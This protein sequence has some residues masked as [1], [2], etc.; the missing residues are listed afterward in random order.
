MAS[1][2]EA[3]V[4]LTDLPVDM[5]PKLVEEIR[6]ARLKTREQQ[7]LKMSAERELRN[8][9]NIGQRYKE[10]ALD[11]TIGRELEGSFVI[12]GKAS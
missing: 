5:D 10:W 1:S 8:Q 2:P 4:D 6:L 7:H 12:R 11:D 9:K 3:E